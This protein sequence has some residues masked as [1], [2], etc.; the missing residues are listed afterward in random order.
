MPLQSGP[1]RV[2][3]FAAAFLAPLL[4]VSGRSG[5]AT[6]KAASLPGLSGAV[7]D[8][9]GHPVPGATVYIYTAGPRTGVSPFCPSCYA[10][11]GK[12]QATDAAGHFRIPQLSRSLVFRLLVVRDGYAPTFVPHMDP[13]RGGPVLVRLA[14]AGAQDAA[15][16]VTGV[17]VGPEGQPIAGATVEPNGIESPGHGEYGEIDGMDPLAVTDAH[18]R[19]RFHCPN[20]DG[21]VSATVKARGLANAIISSLIP[22]PTGAANRVTLAEG[23]AVAGVVQDPRGRGMAGVTVEVVPTDTDVRTFTGWQDI[24]TDAAGRFLVPNVPAGHQYAVC[25]KMD[26]MAGRGLGM[27]RRVVTAGRDGAVTGGVVLNAR[28]AATVT[29]RVTLSDGKPIPAGTRIMLGRTGT[30]D[31]QQATLAP[32]GGFVFPGVPTDE[33]MDLVL[34]VRGYRVAVDTPLFDQRQREVS[35]RLPVGVLRKS[36]PIALVPA[37]NSAFTVR[38]SGTAGTQFSGTYSLKSASQN[39]GYPVSGTVPAEY[40]AT[41]ETLSARFQKQGGPGTLKVEI[42]KSGEVAATSETDAPDGTVSAATR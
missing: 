5:A 33:T 14:R 9:D 32:D 2:A 18:G 17:V 29:G 23:A 6:N 27:P 7:T 12:H 31:S 21:T 40:K 35:L 34:S 26:G 37:G 10:D 1:V 28:P 30:W 8:P 36:V 22:G 16:T 24:G 11:C 25:V 15:R 19:F 4:L 41:T 38:V 39:E 3:A 42:I 20:P 13:L